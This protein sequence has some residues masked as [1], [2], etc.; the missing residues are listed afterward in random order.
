MAGRYS[1]DRFS[2]TYQKLAQ[3]RT[4]VV[5]DAAK[6]SEIEAEERDYYLQ[7]HL[8]AWVGIPLV[9]DGELVA[10]MCVA[11]DRPRRWT[12]REVRLVEETAARLWSAVKW[13]RAERA[14]RE[15]EA[16]TQRALDLLEGI[17]EATE[18]HVVAIDPEYWF[19]AFNSS[20]QNTFEKIFGRRVEVGD[21]L[22]EALAHLPEER[23]KA[24]DIWGRA[25]DGERMVATMEFGD[26]RLERRFFDLRFGPIYDA[27]GEVI[28]AAEFASDVTERVRQ[29]QMLRETKEKLEE[30]NRQK[31]ESLAMLSHELRNPLTPIT[32]SLELLDRVEPGGDK[33]ERAR[34]A[35]ARQV[36]QLSSLVDDLLDITRVN[37]GKVKL[38]KEGLDLGEVVDG[39][40]DA[41]RGLLEGAGVELEVQT[42]G[43]APVFGDCTRLVQV[44]GNLLQ[45][46]AKF[47]T[48]GDRVWVEVQREGDE[49][50]MV[51]EDT[52]MGMDEETLEVVF[53]P[54]AQAAQPLARK[55]GGLGIGL[56]L[57][58]ELIELHGGSVSASSERPGKGARF[59]VRLPLDEGATPKAQPKR[60]EVTGEA[61]QILIIEDNEEVAE[62]FRL[63]LELR[64]HEVVV[65]HDGEEGVDVARKLRPEV[66]SCDVGLPVMNG[67][68]VARERREDAPLRDTLLW[69]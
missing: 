17:T 34:Q 50:L 45:N 66:I 42:V 49:A 37:R 8:V 38:D 18:D 57:V 2:S 31:T 25:L 46:A 12:P 35:I 27:D 19:V 7:Q 41:H 15:S 53:E 1:D 33:A 54:F 23:E 43:E 4:W 29:E 20:Y 55:K 40:V 65:A 13:S 36:R 68:E 56:A 59:E 48:P 16:R 9:S 14:L 44:V 3:G 51:V 58:R 67:Y 5:E 64:D 22:V 39:C 10:A 28:A 11:Q 26:P 30:A 61:R 24:L 63:F 6:L 21:C 69:R 52:G 62:F 47:T 60:P 32:F